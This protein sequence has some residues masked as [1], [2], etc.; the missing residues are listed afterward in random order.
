MQTLP[1]SAIFSKNQTKIRYKTQNLP[2]LRIIALGDSLIYGYGDPQGGG[3]IERLRRL[4]MS[5]DSKEHVLYNLGIRGDRVA[6]VSQ[7]LEQEFRYRGELRNRFPD[8]II[9]SVGVNDSPRLGR[10]EGKNFTNLPIFQKDIDH[11][12][13][14]AQQLCP[15]LF[16]GMVPVDETKMPFFDCLYYNLKDQYL[17]KEITKQACKQRGIPYLDTFDLWQQRGEKWCRERLG[18]DGLHPNVAGY[19]ALL[20]DVL[21]WEPMARIC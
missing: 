1:Q 9:L 2:N 12:L 18:A 19:E 10:L 20:E 7:R 3:W 15:V 21:S 8:V 5:P 17:Y 11:L 14:Q 16:I 6:Q 4:W 13:D